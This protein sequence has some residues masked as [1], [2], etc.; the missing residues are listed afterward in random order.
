MNVMVNG[1]RWQLVFDRVSDDCDG[2][3][4]SP[5]KRGKRIVLRKSLRHRHSRLLATTIHELLHAASWPLSEEFVEKF[6]ED[7]ERVL[8]KQGWRLPNGPQN[9]DG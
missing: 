6:A 1:K 9:M 8:T 7:A 2:F 4:D 5:V 3:C